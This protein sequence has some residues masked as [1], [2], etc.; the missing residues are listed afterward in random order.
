MHCR[1]GSGF[2]LDPMQFAFIRGGM[3]WVH[4][5][6]VPVSLFLPERSRVFV[7]GRRSMTT[8]TKPRGTGMAGDG[9]KGRIVT[10]M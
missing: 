10:Q 2:A 5:C 3:G 9:L 7:L 8:E 1:S 4:P 6:R